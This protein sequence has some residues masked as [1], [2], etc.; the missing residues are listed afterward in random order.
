[1]GE[2]EPLKVVARTLEF[3]GTRHSKSP[4]TFVVAKW[5]ESREI[6][7]TIPGILFSTPKGEAVFATSTILPIE[8]SAYLSQK[9]YKPLALSTFFHP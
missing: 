4:H 9:G 7:L 8:I 5:D 6:T 3:I 1:V 2:D